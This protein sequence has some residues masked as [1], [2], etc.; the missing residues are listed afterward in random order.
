[1]AY[2]PIWYPGIYGSSTSSSDDYKEIEKKK[3]QKSITTTTIYDNNTDGYPIFIYPNYT[4]NIGNWNLSI[5]PWLY[6][7]ILSSNNQQLSQSPQLVSFTNSYADNKYALV[8]DSNSLKAVWPIIEKTCSAKNSTPW[9]VLTN[10]SWQTFRGNTFALH[11]SSNEYR[12]ISFENCLNVTTALTLSQLPFLESNKIKPIE[13]FYYVIIA[14][15]SIF[16]ILFIL[17]SI[18][19]MIRRRRYNAPINVFGRYFYL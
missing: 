15:L 12:N 5:S 17:G 18:Y 9:N 7:Y 6:F 11:K 4:N 2:N 3:E 19:I 1:M 16:M 13:I 14:L 10:T 8:G